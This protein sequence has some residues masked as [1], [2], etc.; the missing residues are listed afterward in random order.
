MNKEQQIQEY[1]KNKFMQPEVVHGKV[2]EVNDGF[3]PLIFFE[4][5]EYEEFT[6]SEESYWMYC[7]SADGFVDCTDWYGPFDTIDDMND[8]IL[9]YEVQYD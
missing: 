4:Q 9:D 3:H 6:I 1:F 2:V 5:N 7:L 8:F